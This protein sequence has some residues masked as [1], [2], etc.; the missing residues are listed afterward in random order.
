MF[1]SLLEIFEKKNHLASLSATQNPNAAIASS[2]P[3]LLLQIPRKRWW[4]GCAYRKRGQLSYNREGPCD[5]KSCLIKW[6]NKNGWMWNH[7]FPTE[8]TQRLS[9][10][11]RARRSCCSCAPDL[12]L[13]LERW[14]QE[15]GWRKHGALGK[16]MKFTYRKKLL[17]SSMSLLRQRITK[18]L[19]LV[20]V[21]RT[22]GMGQ[23]LGGSREGET[24]F[25]LYVLIFVF[26]SR[27]R[28]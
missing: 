25:Y 6:S 1:A 15:G 21:R 13:N 9:S 23:A 12:D 27:S 5:S 11:S 22:W 17:F 4:W 7:K 8:K 14:S 10:S 19:F 28:W 26:Q 18:F 3:N 24:N 16:K 20:D 2:A